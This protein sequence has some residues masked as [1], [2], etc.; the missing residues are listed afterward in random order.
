MR[1]RQYSDS[2]ISR[3]Q[4]IITTDRPVQLIA[5]VSEGPWYG[6]NGVQALARGFHGGVV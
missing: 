1:A 5:H 6:F 3:L 4:E 2:E